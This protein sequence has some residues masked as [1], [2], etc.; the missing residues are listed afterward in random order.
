MG[1]FT[2]QTFLIILINLINI[3]RISCYL[4]HLS[5]HNSFVGGEHDILSENI[6]DYKHRF[7][8]IDTEYNS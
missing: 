8:K 4:K 5:H 7:Y 3:A 6:S 1:A 2:L